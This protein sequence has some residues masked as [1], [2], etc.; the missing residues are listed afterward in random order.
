MR[1]VW[2]VNLGN[3]LEGREKAIVFT[4]SS[5]TGIKNKEIT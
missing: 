1:L 4:L 2:N 5:A 3:L